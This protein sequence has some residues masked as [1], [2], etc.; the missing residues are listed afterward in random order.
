[1]VNNSYLKSRSTPSNETSADVVFSLESSC[2]VVYR[3]MEVG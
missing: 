2:D 3:D 1:L